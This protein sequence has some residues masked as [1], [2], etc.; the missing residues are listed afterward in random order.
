MTMSE[1]DWQAHFE[2]LETGVLLDLLATQSVEHRE[3]IE[4]IIAER[5]VSSDDLE[6]EMQSRK[7]KIEENVSVPEGGSDGAPKG[8]PLLLL[9]ILLSPA[10]L[11]V[12]IYY[13]TE[14]RI[15]LYLAT[16]LAAGVVT[17]TIGGYIGGALGGYYD[18]LTRIADFDSKTRMNIARS[19]TATWVFG[20]IA[21][22]ITGAVTCAIGDVSY[23]PASLV[24]AWFVFRFLAVRV[25]MYFGESVTGLIG[26]IVGGAV[27]GVLGGT[28]GVLLIDNVDVLRIW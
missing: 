14:T 2:S 22:M 18:P 1:A 10:I 9:L 28:A 15:L 12:G 16:G 25:E 24:I 4:K 19:G 11:L 17:G 8:H 23:L 27:A 6:R 20:T 13:V 26:S 3:M 21:G 7:A 5:G